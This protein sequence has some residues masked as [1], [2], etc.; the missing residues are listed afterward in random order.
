MILEVKKLKSEIFQNQKNL[1][2][3]YSSLNVSCLNKKNSKSIYWLKTLINYD[4]FSNCVLVISK[5]DYNFLSE[6]NLLKQDVFHLICLSD[7]K[8][9]LAYSIFLN[10]CLKKPKVYDDTKKHLKNKKI[11]IFGNVF[12]F[13]DVEIGDGTIIYPN[14]VIHNN[15]KIGK[16]CII[17][18][19]SSL[20]T[21]GMG[22]EKDS[23]GDW[24]HFPQVGG[25]V[26]GDN[27]EIGSHSD[28]KKGA[29]D[30]T[31]VGRN[32][33]LGSFTNIGH[34]CIIGENSLFTNHCVVGGSTVIGKNFFMGICS[35][36]KNGLS[37]GENV[38]V[39]AN[40]FVNENV[41]NNEL[42]F[43]VNKKNL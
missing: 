28:L 30:N 12:I 8:P 7:M 26:V 27:V 19:N 14:V 18:E 25:L 33:K 40:V 38:R 32:C 42:T 24:Y 11:K 5:S 36:I 34:N 29:I 3:Q 9:R 41:N 1:K 23:N 16:N 10:E 2:V 15:V 6:K 35:S 20:G 22:F 13:N 21:T 31:I 4:N 43:G 17:R 37:I 39:A